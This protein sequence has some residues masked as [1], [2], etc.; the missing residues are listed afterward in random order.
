VPINEASLEAAAKKG[1]YDGQHIDR[2]ESS[3]RLIEILRGNTGD[4]LVDADVL[5]VE[6]LTYQVYE[7]NEPDLRSLVSQLCSLSPRAPVQRMLNGGGQMLCGRRVERSSTTDGVVDKRFKTGRFVSGDP[8]VVNEFLL[9]LR[10]TRLTHGVETLRELH[11][12]AEKRIPALGP[13][14]GQRRRLLLS[15][16]QPYLLPPAAPQ[17]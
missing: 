13:A 4:P 1:L 5:T 12:L 14:M 16:M 11:D 2:T 15:Q 8:A 6:E 10:A 9:E 7:S 3:R 17:P